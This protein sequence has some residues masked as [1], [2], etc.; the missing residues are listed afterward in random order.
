[1]RRK[2]PTWCSSSSSFTPT[3]TARSQLS[4]PADSLRVDDAHWL[5]PD[6]VAAF[7]AVLPLAGVGLTALVSAFPIAGVRRRRPLGDIVSWRPVW[8][9]AEVS[10]WRHRGRVLRGTL[11]PRVRLTRR[12]G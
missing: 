11:P 7:V 3:L 5:E 2:R 1:M 12:A 4:L 6:S 8:R 10:P 9:V